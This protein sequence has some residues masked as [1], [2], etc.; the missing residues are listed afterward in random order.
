MK[1]ISFIISV[2]ILILV[3]SIQPIFAGGGQVQGDKGAGSVVQNGPCPFG[4]DTP[5]VQP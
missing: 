4:Q 2:I 3:L 5:P 1:K